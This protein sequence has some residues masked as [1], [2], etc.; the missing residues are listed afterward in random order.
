MKTALYLRQIPYAYSDLLPLKELSIALTDIKREKFWSTDCD[1]PK[2]LKSN[3][4][5]RRK[6]TPRKVLAET[7]PQNTSIVNQSRDGSNSSHN[8]SSQCRVSSLSR[9]H[10]TN[11]LKHF[12]LYE[13]EENLVMS[14]NS[15]KYR[16]RLNSRACVQLNS[17]VN[18]RT[19]RKLVYTAEETQ[20]FFN[21]DDEISSSE[22]NDIVSES[23]CSDSDSVIL[24]MV[25]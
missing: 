3:I 20:I 12:T 23:D 24:S 18:P 4:S 19:R 2:K 15:T 8:F 21:S 9:Q 11:T 1:A 10:C 5:S 7:T 17:K 22:S 13:E 14:P 6:K 25:S 16:T